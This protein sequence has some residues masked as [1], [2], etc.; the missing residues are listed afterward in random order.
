[1]SPFL[2]SLTSSDKLN[3]GGDVWQSDAV[4]DQRRCCTIETRGKAT[5]H[6]KSS[7][8]TGSPQPNMSTTFIGRS[9]ADELACSEIPIS[10]DPAKHTDPHEHPHSYTGSKKNGER[11]KQHTKEQRIILWLKPEA[12]AV[13]PFP[14]ILCILQCV[15]LTHILLLQ[16]ALARDYHEQLW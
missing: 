12:R 8:Q 16:R 6:A 14:S 4:R 11:S 13:H 3:D 15:H 2:P 1:M 5:H 7:A 9:S 10:A